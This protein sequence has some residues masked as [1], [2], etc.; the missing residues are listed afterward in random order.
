MNTHM[1]GMRLSVRPGLG[2][3]STLWSFISYRRNLKLVK[4]PVGS[5]FIMAVLFCNIHLCVYGNES[6]KRFGCNTSIL[7]VY[8]WL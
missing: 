6:S 2:T 7:P 3:I 8:L 4:S 5:Y 1:S